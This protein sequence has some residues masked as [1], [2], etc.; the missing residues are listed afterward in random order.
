LC[1]IKISF[2][3]MLQLAHRVNLDEERLVI[4]HS[5][6]RAGSTL[7]SQIFAQVEGVINISEP[8]A[9]TWMV[10]ARYFQ[11]DKKAELI[12]L[13]NA[14]IHMLCKT[15]AKTAW[16]IKGRS[17]IVELGDWLYELYPHA[18]NI[19]LYRDAETWLSSGI[20]AYSDGVTRTATEQKQY[21][22]GLRKAL[23][24]GTPLI[25][26][27][28]TDKHLTSTELLVLMW[29][30]VMQKYV[31]L[32]E[33]GLNMLAICYPSWQQAPRE[34]AIAMLEYCECRPTDMSAI[35]AT[36][37]RDSQAGTSLS[38]DTL[39]KHEAS[40]Q[41]SDLATLNL[42]LGQHAY[43]QSADFE[44]PNTLKL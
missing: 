41:P 39:Q 21:E 30:S 20:R 5:V 42:H 16:V 31:E 28:D 7:A 25:A 2:E 8:D 12:A 1:V 17:F 26:Q 36:L 4:L 44:A 24:L 19:F 43:I 15:P 9:I 32:H 29:L 35:D 10:G 18:K 13:L 11:P 33:L 14:T 27:Y 37:S 34:T 40:I 3:T 23:V 38:R 22:Q 6:G